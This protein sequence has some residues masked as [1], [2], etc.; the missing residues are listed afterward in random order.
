VGAG[1]VTTEELTE[2]EKGAL[3][4][5]IRVISEAD[6]DPNEILDAFEKA[7]TILRSYYPRA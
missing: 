6:V 4:T 2:L 7:V 5:F 1:T 3:E